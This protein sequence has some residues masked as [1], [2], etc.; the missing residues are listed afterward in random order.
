MLVSPLIRR[1]PLSSANLQ[2]N[3]EGIRV[4]IERSYALR[5]TINAQFDKVKSLADGVL[6]E[7]GSSRRQDLRLRD[8]IRQWQPQLRVL[9]MMRIASLK[10]RLQLPGFELPG[11][12]RMLQQ[13]YDDR[14]A[15]VLEDLAD[16][17]E[18]KPRQ[19]RLMS[20]D[21]F[22]HLEQKANA[23]CVE[24][25]RGIGEAHIPSFMTLLR[26]IDGLTRSLA[27]EIT[28]EFDRTT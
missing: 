15:R 14:S 27:E 10:Y 12:V 3:S 6:F 23:C 2:A 22:E 24:E 1:V 25:K 11:S 19:G 5:E 21:S 7:F 20:G 13:E 28:V 16:W 18:D 17:I 8:H 9:F 4:A 26:G